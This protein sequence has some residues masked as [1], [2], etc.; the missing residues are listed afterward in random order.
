M[1]EDVKFLP[2]GFC[3]FSPLDCFFF[4][5]VRF[6]QLSAFTQNAGSTVYRPMI[7]PIL[8]TRIEDFAESPR[9]LSVCRWILKMPREKVHFGGRNVIPNRRHS[10][11]R[12]ATN[13]SNAHM[14]GACD[15]CSI[16]KALVFCRADSARLCLACDAQVRTWMRPPARKSALRVRP[17]GG[18]VT[19]RSVQG[20]IRVTRAHF[21]AC[22]GIG[23]CTFVRAR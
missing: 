20:S 15:Y 5:A 14:S 21:V 23:V 17:V 2:G 16:A 3:H 6:V 4:L 7:C 13:E 10:A 9:C 8:A 19:V 12:C 22:A 1:K 18:R 11:P